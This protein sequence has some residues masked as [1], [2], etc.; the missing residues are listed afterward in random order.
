MNLIWETDEYAIK[1]LRS[2]W[3]IH[4]ILV[5]APPQQQKGIKM[6][7]SF[8]LRVSI[9]IVYSRINP[10]PPIFSRIAAS[11]MEPATGA[12]TWALGSHRWSPNIGTLTRKAIIQKNGRIFFLLVLG[13]REK[14]EIERWFWLL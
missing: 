6:F 8:S 4:I 9:K 11:I 14:S 10:Y 3:V 1:D 7:L 2:V 13:N 12:S 5:R